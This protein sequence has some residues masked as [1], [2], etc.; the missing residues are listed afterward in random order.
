MSSPLKNFFHF[1]IFLF[2]SVFSCNAVSNDSVKIVPVNAQIESETHIWTLKSI[3]FSSKQTIVNWEVYSKSFTWMGIQDSVYIEDVD[4]KI[5]YYVKKSTGIPLSPD[6]RVLMKGQTLNYTICFDPIKPCSYVNYHASPTFFVNDININTGNFQNQS[7]STYSKNWLNRQREIEENKII[8]DSILTKPTSDFDSLLVDYIDSENINLFIKE[9]NEIYPRLKYFYETGQNFTE[10]IDGAH[11]RLFDDFG[12]LYSLLQEYKFEFSSKEV[13]QYANSFMSKFNINHK[14]TYNVYEAN[15]WQCFK[16]YAY[17]EAIRNIDKAIAAVKFGVGKTKFGVGNL[18]VSYTDSGIGDLY[19]DSTILGS[20]YLQKSLYLTYSN[21]L[22]NS[23]LMLDTAVCYSPYIFFSSKRAYMSKV[24]YYA[25]IESLRGNYL[26]SILMIL[27][28]KTRIQYNKE[29]TYDEIFEIS[30]NY[31]ALKRYKESDSLL[32]SAVNK[33]KPKITENELNLWCFNSYHFSDSLYSARLRQYSDYLR[34][35]IYRKMTTYSS[36]ERDVYWVKKSNLLNA[37]FNWGITVQS[38]SERLKISY[39]NALFTKSLLLNSDRTLKKLVVSN[40]NKKIIENYKKLMDI[41]DQIVYDSLMSYDFKSITEKVLD[42][43]IKIR[44]GLNGFEDS[45]RKKAC[46]W[47]DIKNVLNERELAIEIINCTT[48]E[49]SYYVA[50]CIDTKSESPEAFVLCEDYIL[51]E[52]IGERKH[53]DAINSIYTWDEEGEKL[54]NCLLKNLFKKIKGYKKVYISKSGTLHNIN[55]SIIPISAKKRINDIVDIHEVLTTKSLL[56]KENSLVSETQD[57]AVYGGLLYTINDKDHLYESSK[58]KNK[59]EFCWEITHDIDD[60][61]GIRNLPWTKNESSEIDSLLKKSGYT[62]KLFQDTDGIEESF[63]DLNGKSPTILHLATH[64]FFL[65]NKRKREDVKWITNSEIMPQREQPLLYSGIL[66]SGAASVWEGRPKT[67]GIDD[68]ILTSYEISKLDLSNTKI[69]VLSACNTAKGEID[70]VDGV[71]G[72]QRALKMAGV[73]TIVMS[74]WQVPDESTCLL[75]TKFY[76]N[77]L[78]GIEINK[79]LKRAQDYIKK[80]Y[81]AP[82]YWGAFIVLN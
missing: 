60:R 70:I 3:E 81:P 66:M 51:R 43:E 6:S 37:Y 7:D 44:K 13:L 8:Y 75:M 73:N 80:K 61:D 14:S 40:E 82:F 47:N 71:F 58:Y 5:R 79:A 77:L 78:K 22:D 50:L 29:L 27:L 57:A 56:N 72:L 18:Y 63:K 53:K 42:L 15:A 69:A 32:T 39:D 25:G 33:Y 64:G 34:S 54:Y 76:E 28:D 74:L 46:T 1:I 48:E 19:N 23:K 38:T 45:L 21:D 68:G 31:C 35:D 24:I 26:E 36:K 62:S 30:R 9:I 59:S 20:L 17:D 65:N 4:T 11:S 10:D 12:G 2:C 52:I 16:L 49:K 41:Q 67:P 55:L